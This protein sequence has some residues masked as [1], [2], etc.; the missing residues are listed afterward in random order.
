MV[1]TIYYIIYY[2]SKYADVE[3]KESFFSYIFNN[4]IECKFFLKEIKMTCL[5]IRDAM[6][7]AVHPFFAWMDTSAP[8]LSKN[9]ATCFLLKEKDMFM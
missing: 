1:F 2:N 8:A 5:P 4:T 3:A 7:K 9:M 6:S